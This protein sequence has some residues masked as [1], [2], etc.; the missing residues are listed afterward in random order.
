MEGCGGVECNFA[1]QE[2]FGNSKNIFVCHD[3]SGGDS[4]NN[5]QAHIRDTI[6]HPAMHK[7]APH[8]Q[9]LSS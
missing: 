3:L 4:I 2:M 5:Q 7:I 6:K 9:E 8:D 1:P